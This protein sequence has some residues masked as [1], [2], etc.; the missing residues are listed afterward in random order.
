MNV[1][2][3]W[4]RRDLRLFDNPA[5][6]AAVDN[7]E[8]IIPLFILDDLLWES[9]YASANRI[10]FLLEG[11]RRLDESL[12]ERKSRLIVRR[13]RPL[14]VLTQLAQEQPI[15]GIYAQDDYSPYAEKRDK[16]IAEQLPLTLTS[17]TA[18]R[19]AG[20]V[21]KD[22]GDPYTV[23]TPFKNKWLAHPLPRANHL[24][25]PPETISTPADLTTLSI[26]D[27]PTL[28]KTI[29]FVAGE[30]VGR[31]QL[32]Q[33]VQEQLGSYKQTRDTLAVDGTSRLS[34]YLRFGMI[35]PREAAVLA[36][37]TK[38]KAREKT[39]QQGAQTWLQELI[40][41]DFYMHILH[42]FPHVRRES[43]RPEYTD[44]PWHNDEQ[45]FAAWC[46]GQ[47][48]YPLV[49][50]AIRQLNTSGWMHNRARM[51]VASFLVKDLLID[52]RWG[53]KYFMQRLLD[54]D[55]AANNGGWQWTA[56]T[57]TDAAP[58]F[59]IF[60]PVSQSEKFDKEGRY[61]RRWVPELA[62]VPD[63]YIHKPWEMSLDEQKKV[64]CI[65]GQT[66]PR[67]LVDHQAARKRTLEAYKNTR[68]KQE[69]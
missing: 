50:A 30:K 31:K 32:Q 23:Y 13:G 38:A 41:R 7:G 8:Q 5:L 22:D 56:G 68:A 43:F 3:W 48:G 15:Q 11:L 37:E 39:A 6:K 65:I 64:N 62:D 10:A 49:D 63:K 20:V 19:P 42:H 21:L 35:S 61:I 53:E 55:P 25:A 17:G 29:P 33:F 58:Y 18:I 28:D 1:T 45:E 9:P 26:P 47:T 16:R 60:N 27:T 66:Y 36:L 14:E 4:I 51:I 69:T 67:P 59:R 44:M 46:A 12:Q 54:G 52:W 24:Y 34:P 40:W 57:G 2:I